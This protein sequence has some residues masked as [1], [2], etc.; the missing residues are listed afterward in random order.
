M[1]RGKPLCRRKNGAGSA[2]PERNQSTDQ[3]ESLSL[4]PEPTRARPAARRATYAGSTAGARPKSRRVSKP[5]L[6]AFAKGQPCLLQVGSVCNRDPKT[7]V[8]CHS[9][10]QEHGKAG[11]R[12]ADDTYVVWGCS[13]CHRWLDQG[14]SPK[15]VKRAVFDQA[16][17]L[18]LRAWELIS[19]DPLRPPADQA[20][21]RWA[22]AR[23]RPAEVVARR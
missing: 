9:N 21:A 1:A 15:S 12:K 20:L 22:F 19:A 18:Q 11:S 2:R 3:V 8:P 23:L 7:T 6:L 4:A 5:S 17:L 10:W 16:L 13:D 14:P